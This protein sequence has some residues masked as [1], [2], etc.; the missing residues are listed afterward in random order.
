MAEQSMRTTG[1]QAFALMFRSAL[2]KVKHG[3]DAGTAVEL[4]ATE[5]KALLRGIDLVR[6]R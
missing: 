6:P 4:T 1:A 5:A 3:A 2:A